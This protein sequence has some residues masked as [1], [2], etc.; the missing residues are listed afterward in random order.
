MRP[1][2]ALYREA[3]GRLEPYPAPPGARPRPSSLRRMA[4]PRG[5]PRR[6]P[7]HSSGP[8]TRCWPP[9]VPMRSPS[10]RDVN[11]WPPA[12][13]PQHTAETRTELTAQEASIARLA[14]N[15]QTNTEIGAQLFSAPARSNG[16]WATCSPSSGSLRAVSCA[17]CHLAEPGPHARRPTPPTERRSGSRSRHAGQRAATADRTSS[18]HRRPS[19][20]RRLD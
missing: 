10:A 7:A 16:T 12:N 1:L 19:R 8:R 18:S 17:D 4:A 11:C 14:G 13:G 2:T 15:G 6:R 9:W 3:I 20:G 5:P